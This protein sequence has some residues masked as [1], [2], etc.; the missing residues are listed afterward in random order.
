MPKEGVGL[1][2]EK[3]KRKRP[4]SPSLKMNVVKNM[5]GN[6]AAQRGG[7]KVSDEKKKSD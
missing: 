5:Y 4:P 2:H 1:R 3:K 7:S 6:D